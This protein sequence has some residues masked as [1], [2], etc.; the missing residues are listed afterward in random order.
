MT[1]LNTEECAFDLLQ[2]VPYCLP[3]QYDEEE[4]ML[5]YYSKTQKERS[6]H[7]IDA[8]DDDHPY[9][10]SDELEAFKQLERLGVYTQADFFSPSK[11]KDGHYAQRLREHRTATASANGPGSTRRNLDPVR[12]GTGLD[13]PNAKQGFRPR[14]ARRRTRS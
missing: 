2:W 8:W 7:A 13:A 3:S 12:K 14:R 6:D 9:K 4:A 11:A 1:D 5:G 10:S